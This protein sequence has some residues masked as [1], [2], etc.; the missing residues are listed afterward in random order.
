MIRRESHH[1]VIFSR[2]IVCGLDSLRRWCALRTI[3][4]VLFSFAATS[5]GLRAQ[6]VSDFVTTY[7]PQGLAFDSL[8]NL[9]VAN[10]FINTVSK[11]PSGGGRPPTSAGDIPVPG[12]W[13]STRRATS[14]SPTPVRTP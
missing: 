1:Y 11:V 8:G 4:F 6:N 13:R 10:S 14:T 7:S 9:Y 2:T 5:V 3:A 12:R